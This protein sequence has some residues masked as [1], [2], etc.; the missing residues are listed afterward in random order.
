MILYVEL[1]NARQT[2]LDMSEQERAAYM[3]EVEPAIEETTTWGLEL[4]GWSIVNQ[5]GGHDA[6]YRYIS[7]WKIPDEETVHKLEATVEQAGWHRYFEQVNAWGSLAGPDEV[8]GDM[9]Q[10]GA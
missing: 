7:V 4:V 10:S 6:G 5:K 9:I 2:W 3:K 8:I 1:W